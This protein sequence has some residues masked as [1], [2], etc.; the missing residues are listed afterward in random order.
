MCV[1]VY[2]VS[3]RPQGK[4]WNRISKEGIVEEP[5]V[6]FHNPTRQSIL[7]ASGG[8]VGGCAGKSPL[9]AGCKDV[10]VAGN[11]NTFLAFLPTGRQGAESRKV[12]AELGS[13]VVGS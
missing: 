5:Y 11:D 8:V 1:L 6:G 7:V 3:F 2:E 9:D 13:T 10:D 12:P 4:A